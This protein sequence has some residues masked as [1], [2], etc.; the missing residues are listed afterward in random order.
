MIYA[1]YDENQP[2]YGL[3]NKLSEINKLHYVN[4][5]GDTNK[6]CHFSPDIMFKDEKPDSNF[7]YSTNTKPFVTFHFINPILL[8]SYT[9]QSAGE[10]YASHS[11]PKAWV[12][13]GYVPELDTWEEI[14]RKTDQNFCPENNYGCFSPEILHYNVDP[15]YLYNQIKITCIENSMESTQGYK[16]LIFSAV[17][18]FGSIHIR[19][20][21]KTNRRIVFSLFYCTLFIIYK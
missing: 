9:F 19:I 21:C 12:I 18:F 20:T 1:F 14:D 13:E 6:T 8:T 7:W 3:I 5:V 17:E 11:Y 4:A 16:Y 2:I 10:N 15:K